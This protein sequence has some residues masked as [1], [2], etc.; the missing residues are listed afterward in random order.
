MSKHLSSSLT[1][2]RVWECGIGGTRQNRPQAEVSRQ[3][4]MA[5]ASREASFAGK[6]GREAT[7]WWRVWKEARVGTGVQ[8]LMGVL[9]LKDSS[10]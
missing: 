10:H 9:L 4:V 7:E 6:R 2:R 8:S 5:Y 1:W 3:E